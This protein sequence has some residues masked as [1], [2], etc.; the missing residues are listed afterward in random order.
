MQ[1]LRTN[2]PHTTEKLFCVFL[3]VTRFSLP[4]GYQEFRRSSLPPSSEYPALGCVNCQDFRLLDS[5]VLLHGCLLWGVFFLSEDTFTYLVELLY[6][7][8]SS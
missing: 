8:E 2:G 5:F 4:V 3:V 6:H 7:F 1:P